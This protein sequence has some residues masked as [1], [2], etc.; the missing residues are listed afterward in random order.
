MSEERQMQ[1]KH[2]IEV[3]QDR[4]EILQDIL[5]LS[6]DDPARKRRIEDYLDGM[7]NAIREDRIHRSSSFELHLNKLRDRL[8]SPP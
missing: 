2:D 1:L 5:L 4:V 7:H 6:L 3:L 8:L